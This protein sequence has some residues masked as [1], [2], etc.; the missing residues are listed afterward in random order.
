MDEI[1]RWEIEKWMIVGIVEIISLLREFLSFKFQ[2]KDDLKKV[3]ELGP[4]FQE[5]KGFIL[6]RWH[7]GFRTKK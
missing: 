4:W 2:H 7:R 6:K 3:L 1:R 5:N